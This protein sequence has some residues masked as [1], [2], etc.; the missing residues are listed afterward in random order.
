MS[1][2]RVQVL[3]VR[4][5]AVA[6]VLIC[7]LL[8]DVQTALVMLLV[9]LGTT[10]GWRL[11]TSATFEIALNVTLLVSAWSGK[12][13]LYESWI[14]WDMLVHFAATGVLAL[15]ARE[16]LE[17]W[18]P[19]TPFDPAAAWPTFAA[20]AVLCVVWE[21]LEFAGMVLI[22]PDVYMTPLDTIGDIAA[23]MVGAAAAEWWRRRRL[24]PRPQAPRQEQRQR[25]G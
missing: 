12:W 2:G 17:Q 19:R 23:G 24:S 10:I 7:L 6:S 15:L 1:A 13:D 8:G 14:G 21:C 22:D 5:A 11:R 3:V 25:S 18:W 16:M 9:C 4:W 20:A